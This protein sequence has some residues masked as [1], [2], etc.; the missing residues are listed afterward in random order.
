MI[1]RDRQRAAAD[2]RKIDNGRRRFLGAA[3]MTIAG[4]RLA[5]IDWQARSPLR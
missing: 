4:A 1:R 2:S 3:A 5:A